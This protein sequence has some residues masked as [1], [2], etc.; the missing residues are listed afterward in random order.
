[1]AGLAASLSLR[2]EPTARIVS[3]MLA[4]AP[5]R[6]SSE[7]T[8][9]RGVC[10]I[11]ITDGGITDGGITDDAAPEAS[12]HSEDGL[13]VAFVGRL[14]NT[15]ELAAECGLPATDT[16]PAGV[17]AAMF[18]RIGNRAPARLRGVYSV[19]VTDGSTLWGFRDHVGFETL[20][21]GHGAGEVRMASE[22]KQ[23]AAG[24]AAPREPDL[25]ML[26]RIFY[27]NVEDHTRT[28]LGGVRRVLAG[29]I[30]M[31]SGDGIRWRRY[32]DPSGLLETARL[33]QDEIAEGFEEHM[34]RAAARALVG[35]DAVSLSGGIDSPAIA[36]FAAPAHLELTG[37]PL[38]ALSSIYPDHPDSDESDYIREVA[39]LLGLPLHTYVPE[40]QTLDRLHEWVR[41]FDGPWSIWSPF[42]AEE[43]LGLASGLG[44]RTVLTGNLA[45]QVMSM[46]QFV[47]S[48]LVWDGELPAVA[49]YVRR[50]RAEQVPW[51]RI[52]R[53]V[54]PAFVPRWAMAAYVRYHP[55][56]R[57]PDWLD[58]WRVGEARGRN[59]L[60]GRK[61][62]AASQL[63]VFQNGSSLTLEADAINQA[64]YGVRVR[65]PW[66]D[67]DLWEFFISLPAQV[68]FP[69]P[70]S[71]SLVRRLLRG[72]VP[73]RIL[74][75]R[76]KTVLNEWLT[77]TS[78]DYR[79]LRRWLL[80]PSHRMPGVNYE[81]LADRLEREDLDLDS[82]VWA[83]D[84]AAIHAFLD[85]W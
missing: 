30:A 6:G 73:D 24:T 28:S 1:M 14:D 29:T 43:R 85:L 36:A 52:A 40:P 9:T 10:S 58:R 76:D 2:G 69:E 61:M 31:S 11:G 17:V 35:Q 45:E 79:S 46:Q 18:R 16:S 42:G 15:A 60:A 22:A 57:T 38:A 66:A 25:E 5:H 77:S 4:A 39:S 71:K 63:G 32:W 8:V 49:R 19:A 20:F 37:H 54:A 33:S 64:R 81:R 53:Q 80:K 70:Q 67:V 48:H 51:R 83:K 12:L 55:A 44:F 65:M 78:I 72:R 34:A 3:R 74:D 75:R 84:L 47:V 7:R 82:F 21:C 56:L 41:L 13:A 62:W 59:A 68:K 27:V 23:V 26:K 50:E